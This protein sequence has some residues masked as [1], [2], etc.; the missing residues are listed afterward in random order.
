[1]DYVLLYERLRKIGYF[2]IKSMPALISRW[3]VF[4]PAVWLRVIQE[5]QAAAVQFSSV[6]R[7]PHW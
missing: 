1:M 7:C 4:W 2:G 3:E 5:S 6:R